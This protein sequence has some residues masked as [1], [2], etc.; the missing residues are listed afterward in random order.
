MIRDHGDELR[1]AYNARYSEKYGH[2]RPEI[3]RELENYLHCGIARFG[4]ARIKCTNTECGETYVLPFSCKTRGLCPSCLQKNMLQTEMWVVD[5][6]LQ[7]VPHR[8]LI[9]TIPKLPR[10]PFFQS[11]GALNE[12]SRIAWRCVKTFMMDGA[13]LGTPAAVQAIETSGE[14]LEP[15][16]HIHVIA[17]DGVFAENGHFCPA[18]KFD[19]SAHRYLL[20]LWTKAIADFVVKHKFISPEMMGKILNWQHTGFSVFADRRVDFKK[21]NEASVIEMRHLARYISKPPFS[22]EK[23]LWKPGSDRV[24]YRGTGLYKW[25]KQ[26]FETY[27]VL[28]FLAALTSHIPN[29]RQKYVG[30]YGQYSNKTRGMQKIGVGKVGPGQ[31]PV[32][33]SNRPSSAKL[34][35]C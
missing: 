6:I 35:R 31:S 24:I 12:L 27:D 5:N 21:S 33:A 1:D 23:I 32:P 14:Y 22:L 30:Y 16:P 4:F 7:E 17:T 34:G 3:D 9:F 29:H 15:N 2:Y 19:E 8:H 13:G 11:R 18:P 26:N 20:S 10:R 25:H 28:D